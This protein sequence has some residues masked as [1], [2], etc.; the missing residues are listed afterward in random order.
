MRILGTD[1]WLSDVWLRQPRK[2]LGEPFHLIDL[3]RPVPGLPGWQ[4]ASRRM[5][6]IGAPQPAKVPKISRQ[7]PPVMGGSHSPLVN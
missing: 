5:D 1:A 2:R 7:E 4:S 3:V 6:L